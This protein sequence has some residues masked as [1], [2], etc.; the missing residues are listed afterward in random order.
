MFVRRS[1]RQKWGLNEGQLHPPPHSYCAARLHSSRHM[2]QTSLPS[3]SGGPRLH[4]CAEPCA[5]Q[6]RSHADIVLYLRHTDAAPAGRRRRRPM[7]ESSVF[8]SAAPPCS[9]K[10]MWEIRMCRAFFPPPC[11][12]ECALVRTSLRTS[13]PSRLP[14]C[15]SHTNNAAQNKS[16]NKSVA[17][18]KYSAELELN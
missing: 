9:N 17:V 14:N 4:T 3:A 1:D 18:E 11:Y 13:A 12:C 10:A 7:R 2:L 6:L 5:A 15:H 8:G 16:Q